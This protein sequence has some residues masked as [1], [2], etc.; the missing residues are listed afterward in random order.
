MEA[1]LVKPPEPPVLNRPPL[2]AGAAGAE[3]TP[4]SPAV[5]SAARPTPGLPP[6]EWR[7]GGPVTPE[8]ATTG[9][10]TK[11][12]LGVF[13]LLWD[14]GGRRSWHPLKARKEAKDLGAH[15]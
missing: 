4:L 10:Q 11:E 14:R 6:S 8:A 13:H 9:P 7:G 2:L 3:E 12:I 1:L 15:A 5:R